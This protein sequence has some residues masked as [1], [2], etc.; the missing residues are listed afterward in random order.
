MPPGTTPLFTWAPKDEQLDP[1]DSFPMVD[2]LVL[3]RASG[4]NLWGWLGGTPAQS[5]QH[6][7]QPTNKY[8]T[9]ILAIQVSLKVTFK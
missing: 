5:S 1:K 9:K 6:F 8:T 4:G 7:P 3:G 2:V